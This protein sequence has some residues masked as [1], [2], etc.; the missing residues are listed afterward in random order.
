MKTRALSTPRRIVL[1]ATVLLA[2][3]APAARA[4]T[5]AFAPL[6][7]ANGAAYAGHVEAGYSV[8]PTAGN[9]FEAHAF[10][11]PVPSI[12][13]GPIGAPGAGTLRVQRAAGLF[14]FI[15]VDLTSNSA[16]G[17]TYSITGF[18]GLVPQFVDAG[19]INN[20]DTFNTIVGSAPGA[21]IDELFITM[22][23]GGGVTSY[24]VDNIV[25]APV[26]PAVVPEPAS[27]ALVATG[28]LTLGAGFRA[29]RRA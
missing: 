26:D 24:N 27:V 15:S 11:N 17:T 13:G 23:P 19:V 6:I 20:I 12:F 1:A 29:R 5:I 28:L 14:N 22:T 21:D 10:G 18:L 4:Q 8:V 9:W 7:G 3:V 2:A 25:L 16:I